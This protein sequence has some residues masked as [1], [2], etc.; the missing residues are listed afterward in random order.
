MVLYS[1]W[2][3]QNDKV[4]ILQA[5][6]LESWKYVVKD[7]FC[8]IYFFE[9]FVIQF[10]KE[11]LISDDS[12]KY[13]LN[14]W[15]LN[16]ENLF[17]NYFFANIDALQLPDPQETGKHVSLKM[18]RQRLTLSQEIADLLGSRT[19][20]TIILSFAKFIMDF[21]QQWIKSRDKAG[22]ARDVGFF[23][24]KLSFQILLNEIATDRELNT[25]RE[26]NRVSIGSFLNTFNNNINVTD[27]L[28]ELNAFMRQYLASKSIIYEEGGTV[29]LSGIAGKSEGVG[30]RKMVRPARFFDVDFDLNA[31]AW[32]K[33][34]QDEANR[35]ATKN[36]RELKIEEKNKILND[37]R[38]RLS[39]IKEEIKEMVPENIITFLKSFGI[40]PWSSYNEENNKIILHY[41]TIVESF[42]FSFKVILNDN[43]SIIQQKSKEMTRQLLELADL[44]PLSRSKRIVTDYDGSAEIDAEETIKEIVRTGELI[45]RQKLREQ[46]KEKDKAKIALILDITGSME[47]SQAELCVICG[48]PK[49]FHCIHLF[50]PKND[51]GFTFK[52]ENMIKAPA[53]RYAQFLFTL[54]VEIYRDFASE[55]LLGYIDGNKGAYKLTRYYN[56]D[57]LLY[58]VWNIA[59][60]QGPTV[61]HNLARLK[62]EEGEAKGFFE[63]FNKTFV[64][65]ITDAQCPD[66]F[67]DFSLNR[68]KGV[69][70]TN[71]FP[72]LKY[73]AKSPRVNFIY[74]MINRPF[75]DTKIGGFAAKKQE[76]ILDNYTKTRVQIYLLNL[77][78]E[79]DFIKTWVADES[80]KP[81]M[82]AEWSSIASLEGD[83]LIIR[84]P[85]AFIERLKVFINYDSREEEFTNEKQ[86]ISKEEVP[87]KEPEYS[88]KIGQSIKRTVDFGS[89]EV[90]YASITLTWNQMTIPI[91]FVKQTSEIEFVVPD[92]VQEDDLFSIQYQY[93]SSKTKERLKEWIGQD[94]TDEN[95][96]IFHEIVYTIFI[97][98]N[99]DV[100]FLT[101]YYKLATVGEL[102]RFVTMI[103]RR[104]LLQ[105][106]TF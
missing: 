102:Q 5:I 103:K 69:F 88:M 16:A 22:I 17:V 71:A 20:S 73:Y 37:L 40:D 11:Y 79:Q 105:L 80:Q 93:I 84:D 36:I 77:I 95:Q 19:I 6:E 81:A 62:L 2:L 64:F 52:Q 75:T 28:T 14:N 27:N 26:K 7:S 50:E 82:A 4:R 41:F 85:K 106:T 56:F 55:I 83:F 92:G 72:Y 47:Q 67:H 97:I 98:E 74:C 23:I 21:D 8:A 12:G 15:Y 70:K 90:L 43:F 30:L 63:G 49:I 10:L 58:D 86:V 35:G 18:L 33:K 65:V 99:W 46:F 51:G 39:V 78:R 89:H 45:T 38:E 94:S 53:F 91:R 44:Q 57:L 54:M 13:A 66:V 1:L 101:D 104:N 9:P 68:R 34:A 100:I 59:G 48:Q 25:L 3:K 96:A 61:Y 42:K 29:K 87:F 24:Q 32:L 60:S 31:V 76:E